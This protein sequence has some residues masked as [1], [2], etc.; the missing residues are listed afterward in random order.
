MLQLIII[1]AGARAVPCWPSAPCG[2]REGAGA[3]P[4]RIL[5]ELAAGV[6]AG[7]VSEYAG[8]WAP[9]RSGRTAPTRVTWRLLS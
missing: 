1:F 8:W 6:A 7:D 5:I 4:A 2:L 3:V 9:L